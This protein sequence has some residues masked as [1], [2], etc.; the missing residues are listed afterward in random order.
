MRENRS[1]V[2][3]YRLYNFSPKRRHLVKKRDADG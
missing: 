3:T 2:H 1:V